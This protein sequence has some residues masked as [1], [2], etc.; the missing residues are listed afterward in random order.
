MN[1]LSYRFFRSSVGR[2]FL[3]YVFFCALMAIGAGYATYQS[4]FHW[5][6]VNKGEEKI[7]ASALVDAFVTAYTDDRAK[8]LTGDAP[9][10]ASFRAQAIER[11]NQSRNKEDLLHL[12]WVGPPGREIATTATDPQMAETVKSFVGQAKPQPVTKFVQ[13]GDKLLFRTIFPSI[14]SKQSCV[15]CHNQMQ[16]PAA[17]WHLNDVMGASVLDVPADPY[18]KQS[19]RDSLV[20]GSF[21][22]VISILI[23]IVTF[24]LQYREFARRE[25][26][27]RSLRQ[28]HANIQSLNEELE[29]RV[30]E[31]TGELRGVQEELLRKERLATLGQLTATVSHELRNPLGV[32]RN[33]FFTVG[34]A[35]K[36]SGLK[37][38]RPLDRIERNITRCNN[39]I[40]EL[41]DYTRTRDLDVLPGVLDDWLGETLADYPMPADVLL[42][43]AFGADGIEITFD[44]GRLQ[45]VLINLIDNARDA[46]KERTPSPEGADPDPVPAVT[47][48]TIATSEWL[49]IYVTDTGAG[50]PP[51]VLPKIFEPLYSTKGFG[52]GLGLPTVKQ[53]MEQH[54]GGIAID[55]HVGQGTTVTLWL[56]RATAKEIAA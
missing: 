21:V 48:R 7:T 10:P 13:V 23:G 35:V 4:S 9:V 37:L 28:A 22:F 5:F 44:R 46:I 27:E 45:R 24:S 33:S 30:E 15:D 6:E 39:I 20:I 34:E 18:L 31:R 29:Q 56:P 19:T 12:L 25:A 11:F 49:K 16:G 1:L 50:I 32:I 38:D 26:S 3:I 55:S 40:T 8:Y 53:I 41:L 47:I 43:Q 42:N 51:D 14:A 2:S 36:K 17:N 52:V 54:G